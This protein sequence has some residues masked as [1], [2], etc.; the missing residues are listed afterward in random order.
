MLSDNGDDSLAVSGNGPFTFATSVASGSSYQATVSTQPTGPSQMCTVANGSGTIGASN[1]VSVVVTCTTNLFTVGGTVAGLTGS[2]LVLRDN[3]GDNLAIM[4]NGAF[5]FATPVASGGAYVVTVLS[6]PANP[7]QTCLISNGSGLVGAGNVVTVAITCKPDIYTLGGTVSGLTGTGLTLENNGSGALAVTANGAF[8]FARLVAVGESYDITVMAQPSAPA[9][10]CTVTNGIGT[11]GTAN[12][13]SVVVNCVNVARFAYTTYVGA[14]A[15]ATVSAFSI[16]PATGALTL[17]PGSAA[18]PTVPYENT[19]GWAA[20]DPSSTFLYV[21]NWNSSPFNSVAIGSNTVSAYAINPS[22]GALTEIMG[23][24]FAT[25]IQPI[26][27]AVEPTG[28]FAYVTHA[29]DLTV[30]AFSIDP[31]TGALASV[32]G[33]PIQAGSGGQLF[34]HPSGRFL[35]VASESGVWGYSIDATTG[36]LTVVAGSPFGFSTSG[37][38]MAIDRSGSFAYFAGASVNVYAIDPTTGALSALPSSPD[39]PG[40]GYIAAIGSDPNANAAFA[41]ITNP[42]DTVASYALNPSG[43]ALTL[44]SANV[45]S[46]FGNTFSIT[47]EPSGRFVYFMS[48][49]APSGPINPYIFT[50]DATTAVVTQTVGSPI[51]TDTFSRLTIVP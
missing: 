20:S 40:I 34:V 18:P 30:E 25:G 33:S 4:G 23:S 35:Y 22:T 45:V 50:V 39:G 1:V 41:D 44:T 14:G 42:A 49:Q 27:I 13:S 16:D 31:T 6:Q 10:N 29:S 17:V 37:S 7:N 47:A 8:A 19:P 43:G 28:R 15:E 38:E 3:G 11:V 5:A 26:S 32:T 9:Q 46:G 48:V 12:V 51:T 36:A 21:T 2:G 24:P